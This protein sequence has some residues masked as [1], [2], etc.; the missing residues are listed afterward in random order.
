MNIKVLWPG[1]T[2]N[3]HIRNLEAL[4]IQKIKRLAKCQVIVTKAARGIS[5][6]HT[7]RIKD[8][9]ASGLEKHIEN[10]FVVCL[11][12]KGKEV[13][14]SDLAE[15][16]DK[17]AS[18]PERFVTFIV[19]GFLGL[20]DRILKR[21]NFNLSLSRMTFS[22]EISRIML[23]EQIYRSLSIIKGYKYAK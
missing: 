1:K 19:G 15:F 9:E 8:I 14:S 18:G 5:E 4:Y 12:D 13:S 10:D 22:H 21:A 17:L 7:R 6:K 2:Q 23:L 3:D 11:S 16:L 20:D